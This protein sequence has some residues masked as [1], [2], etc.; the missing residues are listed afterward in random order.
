MVTAN[1]MVMYIYSSHLESRQLL[2]TSIIMKYICANCYEKL[3]VT[4]MED[5]T[6]EFIAKEDWTNTDGWNNIECF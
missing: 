3:T 5:I 6:K 4:G 1:K 2:R